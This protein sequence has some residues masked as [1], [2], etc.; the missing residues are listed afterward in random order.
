LPNIVKN[1]NKYQFIYIT[2]TK[3]LN[4]K[5]DDRKEYKEI[6]NKNYRKKNNNLII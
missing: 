4:C 6:L 1:I 2:T 5:G 3:V